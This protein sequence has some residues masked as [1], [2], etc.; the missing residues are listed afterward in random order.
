MSDAVHPSLLVVFAQQYWKR[1]PWWISANV[2]RFKHSIASVI[3]KLLHHVVVE[4]ACISDG[5]ERS[6]G[7]CSRASRS[8]RK[9]T[10]IAKAVSRESK[11]RATAEGAHWPLVLLRTCPRKVAVNALIEFSR[12]TLQPGYIPGIAT[13]TSGRPRLVLRSTTRP[14][15]E[16]TSEDVPSELLAICGWVEVIVTLAGLMKIAMISRA[17][18]L[19]CILVKYRGKS[20]RR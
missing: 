16:N 11:N 13:K 7:T 9:H 5:E 19:I 17:A 8:R 4:M 6:R 12:F 18:A 10:A 1:G 3:G 20:S 2:A 14:C 15:T